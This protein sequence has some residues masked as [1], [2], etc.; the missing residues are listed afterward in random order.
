MKPQLLA[1]ALAVCAPGAALAAPGA[2]EPDSLDLD[3]ELD[4]VTVTARQ[5]GYGKSRTSVT[6]TDLLS[7]MELNRA[8]CCSLGG[9][10][11]TNPSVDVNYTDAAT[12]A[13]QIK[14][15]GLSGAYVQMLTESMPD[16]R[17]AA[18][19]YGLGYIPGR[20]IESIQVSKGASSVKAGNESITGQINVELIKP[21][22]QDHVAA[23]AYASTMGEAEGNATASWHLDPRLSTALMLHY[24]DAKTHD[25][26][27]DGF[28]DLPATR[29]FLAMNRWAWMGDDYK[30]QAG[31]SVMD[32]RRKSGQ[33][34]HAAHADDAHLFRILMNTTRATGFLKNA[35]IWDHA[36]NSNVALLANGSYQN[37]TAH[38]GGRRYHVREN[39]L[40]ASLMFERNWRGGLH[41]LSAGLSF[42]HDGVDGDVAG[43]P[44]SK[45]NED[46][47]GAYAQYT[48]NW[49]RKVLAMA[50]L[51][52]DHSSMFGSMV[53][54]RL[55][56]KYTPV[57]QFSLHGSAGRGFRS[58][59]IMAEYHYLMA[60]SR[61]MIYQQDVFQ[62]DAWNLGAGVNTFFDLW[63]KTLNVNAEY[64]YTRFRHRLA[65]D[66]D[67]DPGAARFID[68][69]SRSRNHTVQ[70]EVSYPIIADMTALVAYRYTDVRVDY[71]RGLVAQ[72]LTSKNKGLVTLG[73]APMMGIWQ[74]DLTLTVTGGGRM[75]DPGDKGLWAR[76]YSAFCG[77][78][79]QVTRNFPHWAVY[80]GGE[81]L[82][83]YTQKNPIIAASD[84]WGGN[85]DATMIYGPLTG[86]MAYVGFRY[87]LKF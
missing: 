43:E 67:S 33:H 80:V 27:H 66:L 38:Y 63:G 9:S 1:L 72:P 74:F 7:A 28:V 36:S 45:R 75:P 35:Y 18:A 59:N 3:Y 30:F 41:A 61:Q 4:A 8:A 5:K 71:G 13:K 20:W 6:N 46:T 53:T 29:Q 12:G 15:L 24:Q 23:N 54:P 70:V 17:G 85:F 69:G 55:H 82:T 57:E 65:V 26:N 31:A 37:M 2:A 49:D 48:L 58:T 60:S 14:L 81:N 32:E 39:T 62:E 19:P 79:A 87:D 77:L 76:R 40:R 16:L 56:L 44:R 52:Y 86:A 34:G 11:T 83:G 78:N 64:Y 84:P 73:Y 51:R 22:G 21:Q 47:P 42:D 50:G 10:F 68:A 25:G